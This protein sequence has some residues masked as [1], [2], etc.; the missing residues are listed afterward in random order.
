MEKNRENM[1]KNQSNFF[2]FSVSS[3][4][5]FLP[6]LWTITYFLDSRYLIFFLTVGPVIRINRV[7]I[8]PN[9]RL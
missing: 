8:T 9:V 1:E 7:K 3:T 6:F 4:F 5:L 2:P